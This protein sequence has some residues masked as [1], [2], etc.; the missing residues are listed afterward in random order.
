MNINA[1]K[2]YINTINDS[3]KKLNDLNANKNQFKV[4][5]FVTYKVINNQ[6]I[7]DILTY[8]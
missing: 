6:L 1:F 5:P 8:V 7:K 4:S 2:Q 3:N